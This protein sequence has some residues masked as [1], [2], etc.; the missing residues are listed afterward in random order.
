MKAQ[1]PL[2]SSSVSALAV[3]GLVL[4]ILGVR[5]DLIQ[6]YSSFVPYF[7]DWGMGAT[8]QAYESGELTA[9][10]LLLPNN[11]HLGMFR[12]FLQIFI[13]DLN[14]SQ[15][16]T[17]LQMVVNAFI[18][19]FTA[20]F[21]VRLVRGPASDI[22]LLPALA[23]ILLLWTFPTSLVNTV[24]GVQTHS[25]F[26]ILFSVMALWLCNAKPWSREWS[27]GLFCL[28][29]AP[30]TMG[31]GSF[32]APA[33]LATQLFRF[34]VSPSDRAELRS[35]LLVIAI[36]CIYS[37]FILYYASSSTHG[38]F[39]ADSIQD[40]L[41]TTF[42]ALS[43]PLPKMV[44]PS[45][46]LLF[47]LIALVIQVVR[48]GGWENRMV[49]FVLSLF[50]F[51]LAICVSIA[52]ARGLN[53]VPPAPRHFEFLQLYTLSSFFALLLLQGTPYRL[54]RVV[55]SLMLLTWAGV[56]AYGAVTQVSFFN[57]TVKRLA[58]HQTNQEQLVR[59]Y[60][61]YADTKLIIEAKEKDRPYP[62]VGGLIKFIDR[63]Q[64]QDIYSY[65]LQ[66]PEKLTFETGSDDF[67]INGTEPIKA[68][69][70][71]GFTYF[72]EDVVGSY[73]R[74]QSESNDR[75]AAKTKQKTY[76][77]QLFAT[78]RKQ[79]MI[80]VSG[81]LGYPGMKLEIV[82][83]KTETRT[84]ILPDQLGSRNAAKWQEVFVPAPDNAF[85][86]VATDNNPE[87]WFAFAAPRTIGTVSVVSNFLLKHAAK[88]WLAGLLILVFCLGQR[89]QR[90]TIGLARGSASH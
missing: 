34:I 81:Y 79:L 54:P 25:Y 31:G 29:A 41:S 90:S 2:N 26:M 74:E 58:L 28:F 89:Y 85:R 60:L 11:G 77:S 23:A 38:Q 56:F 44:W 16:D 27:P 7:D 69:S 59:D 62:S 75:Q 72:N 84:S 24:W 1:T 15:W 82:D 8:L 61:Y 9:A 43:F 51:S 46:I 13:F 39:Y 55:N 68:D 19:L 78:N 22:P 83:V 3:L 47:P 70:T 53:G 21:L 10:F 49:V 50:V 17:R 6:Q 73:T 86:I 35:S 5:L 20:L 80:P 48:N 45:V 63:T 14:Q 57:A 76:V 71:T 30:L 36:F 66:V 42:K 67:L 40:W 87:L 52:Y 33:L 88:I 4:L 37:A 32:V 12:E 18:W 64:A 65:Q